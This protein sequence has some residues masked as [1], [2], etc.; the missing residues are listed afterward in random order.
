MRK[1]SVL[2]LLSVLFFS[3]DVKE[4]DEY[5]ALLNENDSLIDISINNEETIIDFVSSI[6]EIEENLEIIKEKENLITL[7]STSDIELEQDQVDKINDD[8]RQIYELVQENK[9][10]IK[11]LN[12][13]LKNSKNKNSDLK[14]MIERLTKDI[15][16][17]DIE[18][19]T[20]REELLNM[21]IVVDEMSAVIDN[22]EMESDAKT[23]VI[24]E[25]I[26]ELNTAYFVY[27]TKKELKEQKVITTEGGFIGIGKM[28]KLMENFNKDYFTKIDITR[29]KDIE[30][31][32]KK[33]KIVTTHPRDSYKFV[34]EEKVEKIQIIDE[35]EFWSVSKYLVIIVD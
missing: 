4:S 3:C 31:L 19:K 29:T 27:G 12:K 18:I 9:S 16:Q 34:G 26:D 13:K 10:K 24:N 23:E 7:N 25:Q 5:K 28:D 20:L 11:T 22:I 1:F 30:L 21:N 15:E 8:I 6:N 33:V 32:A 2:I 35:K 17:K 14:K